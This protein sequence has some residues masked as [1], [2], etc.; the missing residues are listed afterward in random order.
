MSVKIFV[1]GLVVIL[2]ASPLLLGAFEQTANFAGENNMKAL[3][4]TGSWPMF[5]GDARHTGL[6]SY[7][8][9]NNKGGL[10]W[11]YHIGRPASGGIV[12]T[13]PVVD[14]NGNI[15]VG[16]GKTMYSVSSDGNLRWKF[17]VQG[18]IESSAAV[19]TD[20]NIYFGA[21]DGN[22][23]SLTPDGKLRWKFNANTWIRS[24]PV[25]DGSGDIYFGSDDY[26]FYALH[27]DGT[28]KWKFYAGDAIASSPAI[29]N[30][31][32]YF[33]TDFT[34]EIYSLYINNGTMKWKDSIG[35]YNVSCKLL[36]ML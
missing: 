18:D 29:G 22:F 11:K 26:Y 9:S 8:T 2:F 1:F 7:D 35:F 6:N 28:L 4:A 19:G 23:Y 32:V 33:T 25:I 14:G 5:R 12:K 24:S 10:L 20:G 36:Y 17:E 16:V 21:K 3:K 30:G 34:R 13:S 31:Y 15:Y 27:P